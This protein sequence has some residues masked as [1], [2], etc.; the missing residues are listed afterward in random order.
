MAVGQLTNYWSSGAS[1]FIRLTGVGPTDLAID[2]FN[3]PYILYSTIGTS[4]SQIDYW[5]TRWSVNRPILYV[6]SKF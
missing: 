6:P 5:L 2:K 1:A 3:E 4:K